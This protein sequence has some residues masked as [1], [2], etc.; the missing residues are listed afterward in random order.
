VFLAENIGSDIVWHTT[1][2]LTGLA[3]GLSVVALLA[4]AQSADDPYTVAY[5]SFGPL[6]TAIFIAD[7]DGSHERMLS[8]PSVGDSNP[9]MSRDGQWILFTSRRNGS[10]DIYRARSDGADMER[11]TDDPAFDDQAV[12]SPDGNWLAFVSSRAGQADIWLLELR[13]RRLRNLTNHPGGDYRPAWSPDGRWIAFTS[14]RDSDGAR[15]STAVRPGRS[16]APLQST[17]IYV[18]RADGSGLRR[19]TTS[20][21]SVGGA[22]WSP[23]G[24]QIAVYEAA[25]L[26]WQMMA[27]SFTGPVATSQIVSIDVATGARQVLTSG[28]GRK[29]TPKW[30]VPG[31]VAYVRGSI[32]EKPGALERVNYQSEGITFTDGSAPL[33]GVFSNVNWSS[34]GRRMVFHRELDEPWPP[35]SATFSRDPQF[36]VI[37]TGIF[38]SYSPDGQHMV[39]NTG[40]AG[41]FHNAMLMM[42]A[43]GTNRRVLFDDPN[44][45]AVA[46]VWSPRGDRV[47]FGLGR[48]N[49]GRGVRPGGVAVVGLDGSGLRMLTPVGEVNH[50][51]PSWSPDA[52]RLVFR[53]EQANSKGL[54]ILDIKSGRLTTLT[55]GPW[56]DNFPAW[57]PKGNRIV[58]TSDR[59]GD[60]ELYTIRPDGREL[61]RLTRSRGNDAHAAWSPDGQWIAFASAR[62]GFKDEMPVGEGGGQGAGDI[63]VMRFD[64]SDVRRLTDDAFEEATPAFAP[65]RR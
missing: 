26:D 16:F 5:A 50:G 52:Q 63:F 57:S 37:R 54:I 47:A 29:Y 46:P 32:D 44:E 33:R 9:S 48:F 20:E 14:D 60:W 62:G 25:P 10:A 36:N 24:T 42:N 15:A 1:G 4:R 30:I 41:N 43:D 45:N 35:V 6:N 51:F 40:R 58:F 49:N 12:L 38:P 2:R 13:T 39:V 53:S 65:R 59:D 22:A 28:P 3:L 23:D 27:R 56:S 64:G 11:L 19:F 34:D 61:K 17:S 55:S 31:R 7:A 8:S 21:S 18:M